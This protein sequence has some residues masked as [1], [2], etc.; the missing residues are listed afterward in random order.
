MENIKPYLGKIEESP[1]FL[2][3][4]KYGWYLNYNDT[5]YSVP[6]SFQSKKFDIKTAKKIIDWKD[7]H[8]TPSK[9]PT[10]GELDAFE[11][12]KAKSKKESDDESEEDKHLSKYVKLKKKGVI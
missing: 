8:P 11:K 4:G 2:N 6:E 9:P 10:I 7:A 5:L 3:S 12:A 1:V